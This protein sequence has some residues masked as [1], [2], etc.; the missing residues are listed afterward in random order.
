M[1]LYQHAQT[2]THH[3]PPCAWHPHLEMR[4]KSKMCM[5]VTNPATPPQ[6]SRE[7]RHL[8]LFTIAYFRISHSRIFF[9][10]STNLAGVRKISSVASRSVSPGIG[11]NSA[12]AFSTS[13][14]K[15][16]S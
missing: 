6:I 3:V 16:G 2:L 11:P 10:R 5:V 1:E 8:V 9:A 15:R 4:V 12:L 13:C 7:Q 14:R